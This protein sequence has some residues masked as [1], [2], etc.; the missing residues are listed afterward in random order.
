MK[1]IK[2][3]RLPAWKDDD[4][5]I[6]SRI[7]LLTGSKYGASGIPLTNTTRLGDLELW[8]LFWLSISYSWL[9]GQSIFI[10]SSL[11]P[12]RGR[13]QQDGSE[14][15]SVICRHRGLVTSRVRDV[16]WQQNL[17]INLDRDNDCATLGSRWMY[18]TNGSPSLMRSSH[19]CI[20][21]LAVAADLYLD[22]VVLYICMY[23]C[24][25]KRNL[26]HAWS[27]EG[28]QGH[29]EVS[30]KYEL[31]YFSHSPSSYYLLWVNPQLK[32]PTH[33]AC[34]CQVSIFYEP[35]NLKPSW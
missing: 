3:A 28:L 26:N 31:S 11:W 27:T 25:L 19:N 34:R 23:G 5:W 6:S 12:R 7:W 9:F 22:C 2:W 29:L 18:F 10:N 15:W 13:D 4:F 21:E 20:D 16:I 8:G 32:R 30:W 1:S 35:P 17:A 33:I 14:T 24:D